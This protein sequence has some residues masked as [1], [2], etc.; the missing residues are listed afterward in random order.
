MERIVTAARQ[1]FASG[2]YAATTIDA[3]AER[4]GVARPTVYATFGSKR[5]M[6]LAL[7]DRVEAEAELPALLLGLRAAEGHPRRQVGL[8]VEFNRRL[9]SRG[10][11]V[12]EILRGAGSAEP[13][14]A[15]VWREGERR[16]RQGQAPL[17]RA[18]SAAGAL[19]TDLSVKAA[20]DILWA[21]TGPDVFRLVV[22]ESGWSARRYAGWLVETLQSALFGQ[23][24]A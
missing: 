13:D 12:L 5:A 23:R 4:A 22:V 7:V 9:F 16:R 21:L 17:V 1:L 20:A 8:L 3:I 14:L 11:D 15:E 19:R 24:P 18:W 10:L 2:G 6:L